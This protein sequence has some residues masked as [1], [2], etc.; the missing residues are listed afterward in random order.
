MSCLLYVNDEEAKTKI[1]IDDLY[2]RK[3]RQDLKQISIFEKILNRIHKRIQFTGRNKSAEKFIWF[4]IPEYIFGEPLYD[5]GDCIAYIYTKLE[6]NGFELKYLHP[7]TL[8][9]SWKNWVPSYVRTELKCKMGIVVDEK[10]NIVE[11]KE[12]AEERKDDPNSRI[13]NDRTG[14]SIQKEQKQYTPI[15][16]YKPTGVYNKEMFEKIEK[17]VSFKH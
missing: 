12:S 8:F 1:N 7:N 14:T 16:S 6:E 10:G 17:K 3:Q 15:D 4:T 9:I 13:F 2:E 5:Q 11:S